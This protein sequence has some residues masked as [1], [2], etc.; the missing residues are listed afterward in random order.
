MDLFFLRHAI[1]ENQG[2]AGSGDAGRP[3]SEEGTEKM[4]AVA[5]G[6]RRLDIR[7]E[8][9][10]SSPYVRA[11]QTAEIVAQVLDMQVQIAPE[12][13]PGC[14][15][16]HL[17]AAMQSALGANSV[18]L[19]GHEPSLSM[20]IGELTGGSFVEMKKSALC[21]VRASRIEASAGELLYLLPPRVLRMLG[22]GREG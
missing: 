11:R 15:L 9:A 7:C 6:M 18:L 12:L 1:A 10:L 13:A 2:P 19:V 20:M 17:R 14:D 22:V 8:V 4:H 21:H 3:L 16:E 5:Q